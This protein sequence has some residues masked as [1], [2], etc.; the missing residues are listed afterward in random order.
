[1]RGQARLCL[2]PCP[3]GYHKDPV[4]DCTCSL[5]MVSRSQKGVLDPP[6]DRLDLRHQL[7]RTE[8]CRLDQGQPDY[9]QATMHSR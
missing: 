9:A 3:C 2:Y 6:L 4:E 8:Y 5:S 1:M 7:P